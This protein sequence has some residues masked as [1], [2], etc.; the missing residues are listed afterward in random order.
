MN[1]IKN[2]YKIGQKLEIEI[3]KIFI[4]N[5]LFYFDL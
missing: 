2:N 3:E 1:K 4:S 5:K